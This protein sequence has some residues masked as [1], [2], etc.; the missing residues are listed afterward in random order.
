[1]NSKM[2]KV[3]ENNVSGVAIILLL[4]VMNA[5]CKI[6]IC[7]YVYVSSVEGGNPTNF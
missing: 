2:L 7:I 6:S 1:M 5:I 3:F 4:W